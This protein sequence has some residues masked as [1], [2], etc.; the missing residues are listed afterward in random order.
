MRTAFVQE[1]IQQAG[2]HPDIFLVVGDL[3]FS[4]VE[5]FV[6]EFPN[7]YLNAGKLNAQNPLTTLNTA[8]EST[9][10]IR[11]GVRG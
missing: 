10:Q 4:V 5:P 3:G 6:A 1:L 7:R 8:V 2:P 11:T 9:Q